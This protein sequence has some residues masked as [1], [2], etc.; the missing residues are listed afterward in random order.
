MKDNYDKTCRVCVSLQELQLDELLEGMAEGKCFKVPLA[1]TDM[2]R[3]RPTKEN[4]VASLVIIVVICLETGHVFQ[5]C[6][7]ILKVSM[8]PQ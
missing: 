7:E 2:P 5:D 3:S 1:N 4:S 8:I 6:C